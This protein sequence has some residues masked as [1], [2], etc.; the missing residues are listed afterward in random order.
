MEKIKVYLNDEECKKFENAKSITDLYSI[1]LEHYEKCSKLINMKDFIIKDYQII[2]EAPGIYS[3][4]LHLVK[5]N[6]KK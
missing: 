5:K 3:F 4:I 2:N 1:S 6:G